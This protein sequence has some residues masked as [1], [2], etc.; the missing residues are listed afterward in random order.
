MTRMLLAAAAAVALSLPAAAKPEHHGK[1]KHPN[2][3]AAHRAVEQALKKLTAAQQANEYDLAGHAQKAKDLIEQAEKEIA[4]ARGA[5]NEHD[6]KEK[7]EG[8]N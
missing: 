3:T 6:Q 4:Q 1:D 2:I 5:A 8:S 7:A